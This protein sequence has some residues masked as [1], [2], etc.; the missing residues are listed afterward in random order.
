MVRNT[1]RMNAT[2]EDFLAM[3]AG[4]GY[5]SNLDAAGC[6]SKHGVDR[7]RFDRTRCRQAAFDPVAGTLRGA[8]HAAVSI[9]FLDLRAQDGEVG[10]AVRAAVSAVLADQQLVLGAHVERFETAMASYCGVPHAVGA[11]SGTDALALALSGLGVGPGG[12][13]LTTP[14]SFFATGS[15]SGRVGVRPVR[16]QSAPHSLNLAPAAPA[17]ALARAGGPVAGIVAVHLFGRLADM[18][19]LGALA[20]R[21]GLWIVEDAAQAVGARADGRRA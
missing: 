15:A 18:T 19:A 20:E 17:E 21:H 2:R 12:R 6:P 8:G 10:A 7:A 4:E 5:R 3:R 9:P 11:G 14:L 1:R 16:P 13:G